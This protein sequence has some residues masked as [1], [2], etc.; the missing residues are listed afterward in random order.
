MRF[1]CIISSNENSTIRTLGK[2]GSWVAQS[3]KRL[4]TDFSSGHELKIVR[5]SFASG[6]EW[7]ET[8]LKILFISH[9]PPPIKKPTCK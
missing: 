4:T 1:G 3:V 2:R 7:V 9:C 6:S 8:L 5:S